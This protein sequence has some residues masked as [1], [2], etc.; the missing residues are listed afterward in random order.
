MTV[1]VKIGSVKFIV[2]NI[3]FEFGMAITLELTSVDVTNIENFNI[4]VYTLT[5]ST[6]KVVV[7]NLV[8]IYDFITYDR[9]EC[10]QPGMNTYSVLPGK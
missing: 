4:A 2:N 1:E 6:Q 5:F 9:H 10:Y 3:A 7:S 8:G